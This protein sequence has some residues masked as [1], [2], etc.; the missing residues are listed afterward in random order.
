MAS[1]G[2]LLKPFFQVSQADTN[3]VKD[4]GDQAAAV[5]LETVIAMVTKGCQLTLQYSQPEAIRRLNAV[6]PELRGFAYEGA[7]V[8]LGAIDCIFPW[9]NRT[10]RFLAG[11]GGAYVYAVHIGVGLALARLRRKPERYLNRLDPILGWMAIDGYGFHEGFFRHKRYVGNQIV[12]KH[13][14]AYAQQ[15][16][17]QGLGRAIWFLSGGDIRNVGATIG[18]FSPARQPDLWNGIGLACGYTGGV[19]AHAIEV[20]Q[21]MAGEHRVRLAVG[22]AIAANARH[23]A[24]SPAPYAEIACEQLCTIA[25]IEASKIVDQAF[26]DLPQTSPEPLYAR[27]Q[28][29]LLRHFAPLVIA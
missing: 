10:A 8:G 1:I 5:R 15:I 26:L 18:Q 29:R 12:P 22:A 19:S 14:S 13:L 3:L 2:K 21:S 24:A 11:Q 25:S 6:E 9:Q 23:R 20:L 7:G 16:F 17:D 4:G 27:W 28:Q